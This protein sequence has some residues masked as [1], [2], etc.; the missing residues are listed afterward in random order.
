MVFSIVILHSHGIFQ[1]LGETVLGV[2]GGYET[3]KG[4]F[5][6]TTQRPVVGMD[7]SINFFFPNGI[8]FLIG[9][10][11]IKTEDIG[12]TSEI[13]MAGVTQNGY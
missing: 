10:G 9:F 6:Q 1:M 4:Q 5:L 7:T 3:E 12:Y 2:R 13:D 8:H 11:S